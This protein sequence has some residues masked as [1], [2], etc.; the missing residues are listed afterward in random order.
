MDGHKLYSCGQYSRLRLC[1]YLLARHSVFQTTS[2]L[3]PQSA[4]KSLTVK[5]HGVMNVSSLS[6]VVVAI[7]E[8]LP[9][10]AAFAEATHCCGGLKIFLNWHPLPSALGLCTVLACTCLCAL[11]SAVR[12]FLDGTVLLLLCHGKREIVAG[13]T[14]SAPCFSI[15]L[16]ACSSISIRAKL[17]PPTYTHVRCKF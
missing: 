12:Q 8:K 9:P 4:H 16:F 15:H 7:V 13:I 10:P 11:L 6:S 14:L 1:S 17:S 3:V 5:P 2:Q